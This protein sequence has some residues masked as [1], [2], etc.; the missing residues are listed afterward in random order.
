[1]NNFH[2]I[3]CEIRIFL[4]LEITLQRNRLKVKHRT[5]ATYSYPAP[6][7]SSPPRCSHRIQ[8]TQPSKNMAP[9]PTLCCP[10]SLPAL[11]EEILHAPHPAWRAGAPRARRIL[12]DPG[13]LP[14]PLP[15]L[16]PCTAPS[17]LPPQGKLSHDNRAGIPPL[18]PTSAGPQLLLPCRRPCRSSSASVVYSIV[19][20][21]GRARL[22]PVPRRLGPMQSPAARRNWA[23]LTMTTEILRRP[24]LC[25]APWTVA[26][27]WNAMTVRS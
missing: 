23:C 4:Y 26:T 10:P 20:M 24:G 19:A 16:P 6:Y 9:P 27:T 7:V 12:T 1:M 21:H 13:R 2:Y 15:C 3:N 18:A 22:D 8:R 25:C 17:R 14:P 11:M 5:Y